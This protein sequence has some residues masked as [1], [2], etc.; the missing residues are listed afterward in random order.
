MALSISKEQVT[1]VLALLRKRISSGGSRPV[2][3]ELSRDLWP[4]FFALLDVG[5]A[6]PQM[7]KCLHS[8][9]TWPLLDW[10]DFSQVASD[11]QLIQEI[12]SHPT[13]P[14]NSRTPPVH[15]LSGLSTAKAD[16]ARDRCTT[17]DF[18]LSPAEQESLEK[19][20]REL[21]ASRDGI[22][23]LLPRD[24]A[25]ALYSIIEGGLTSDRFRQLIGFDPQ[26]DEFTLTLSLQSL[27]PEGI[28][29]HRDLYWPKEWVG[30]DVF[31]VFYALNS[32]SPAKGGAF[33]YYLQETN[34]VRAVYRRI[35][36]ATILWNGRAT[37][38]RI[39]H[40]VSGYL[41]SDTTRHL[42]ILQCLCRKRA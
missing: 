30:Q 40:A 27:S 26:S 34:E 32:D 41:G 21:T 5:A 7:S 17:I 38:G 13:V 10:P 35:H 25:P 14:S 24:E 20:V 36:D 28:S 8:V 31:A 1:A 23:N 3:D 4:A 29:W 15:S 16:L 12:V 2:W 19:Q 33:L 42:I 6:L 18:F 37:E 11:L 39:L 9:G 22:W